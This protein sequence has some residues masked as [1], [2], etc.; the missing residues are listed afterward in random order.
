MTADFTLSRP[1]DSASDAEFVDLNASV[2]CRGFSG[3]TAFTVARRDVERFLGDAA[4][5]S[6]QTSDTAQ[7]LGGWDDA[8][9][10]LRLRITRAGLS[11]QFTAR[12]RI[13]MTGPREEQWN[14]VETEFVCPPV[15]LQTFL[16][17]LTRLV[18]RADASKARLTGD[19]EAIA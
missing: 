15:A 8:E 2:A 1:D 5:L 14:R 9:E 11:G 12:V 19:A 7:L 4:N 18:A 17:D 6:S 13:A 16:G 3:R 10:R